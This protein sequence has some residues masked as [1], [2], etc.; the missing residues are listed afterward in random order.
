M[1]N[2]EMF[3][4]KKSLRERGAGAIE[5]AILVGCVAIALSFGTGAIGQSTEEL[6][7]DGAVELA[8]NAKTVANSTGSC[9]NGWDL[10]ANSSV[11]PEDGGQDVDANNDGWVCRRVIPGM[12]EGNTGNNTNVKDNN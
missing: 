6:L 1:R 4:Q 2:D 10:V 5:V 8:D 11:D 9:P 7:T 3:E 12:G